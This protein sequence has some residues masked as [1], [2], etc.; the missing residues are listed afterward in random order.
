[1][2]F[3]ANIRTML[4]G[5]VLAQAIPLLFAPLLTRLYPP[6]A[7]GVQAVF[8]GLAAT[9]TAFST[10]RLDLA[11]LLTDEE[12]EK[13]LIGVIALVVA[14]VLLVLGAALAVFGNVITGSNGGFCI[15][16]LLPM[17][18]ASAFMVLS[19][20]V[21]TKQK[22]F[23]PIARANVAN[24]TAYVAAAA[25]IPALAGNQG[26]V[27]AK[28]A[29]QAVGAAMVA[30]GTARH[31]WT[32]LRLP[33]RDRLPHLWRRFRQFVV[34]NAP[35]SVVGTIARDMP[36]YIFVAMAAT[37]AAGFYSI[38]RMLLSIPNLIATAALSQVFYREALDLQG[39]AH[40]E[41]LTSRLLR[42]TLLASAP[43]FAFV[44]TWGDVM[45]S[46]V[47]GS[48][49]VQ[50]GLY[51][52]ILAPA[53]W[54][55]LQT[56]WPERLFEVAGRQD[57]S[58]RIQVTF[59]AAAICAVTAP[60][61]YGADPIWSVAGFAVVNSLYH[62]AYLSA[63]FLVSGFSMMGLLRTVLTGAGC[64]AA[65]ALVLYVIRLTPASPIVLS[66]MS[67]LTCAALA[68]ALGLKHLRGLMHLTASLE[69]H[70]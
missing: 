36:V 58:F 70:N 24:Q 6:E 5:F 41:A 13:D 54:L 43:L 21:L 38:A 39:T 67:A 31:L 46:F 3:L 29:G 62:L 20:A 11:L 4:G 7:V 34:Y 28:L 48:K 14:A 37:A 27:I 52:M 56:G 59:D 55:S 25:A 12:E 49:W 17:A 23:G 9:I 10:L 44:L 47:F 64:L 66:A 32:H 45:L 18:A 51:A 8:M 16:L 33:H 35:Y 40:F 1:M 42:L 22:T 63:I 2:S 60:I 61:A 68:L 69:G 50:A 65:T 19:T 57:L 15:W 53:A 26:L 30:T